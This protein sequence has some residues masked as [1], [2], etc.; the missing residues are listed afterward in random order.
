M[1]ALGLLKKLAIHNDIGLEVS[2]K[3]FLDE[4]EIKQPEHWKS[5]WK[6]QT[7]F[8]QTQ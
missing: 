6:P 2:G 5:L 4:S 1:C 7:Q 8:D 3:I